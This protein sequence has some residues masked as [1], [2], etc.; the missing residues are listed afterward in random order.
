MRHF[1]RIAE[2]L[3]VQPVLAA[4]ARNPDLWDENPLRTM[5]PGTAHAEVSDIWLFFNDVSD[6]EA[7]VNDREVVPYR[8]WREI[9]QVRALVLNLMRFVD[10]VRLGR[11]MIT[12]LAPGR[13]ITPHVD[14][15]AP[16]EYFDR[17]HIALQCLPGA[18]FRAGDETVQFKAGD[19]FWFDN[20]VEHEVWNN[21][22][23]D[24]IVLICDIRSE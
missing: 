3:D 11:V 21:S 1:H 12:R 19:V 9:P 14:G 22:A 20:T 2:G 7:V 17:Y 8:G 24:R 23:D 18:L 10:G 13:V 4:L 15:G 6:P 5:H 16:A